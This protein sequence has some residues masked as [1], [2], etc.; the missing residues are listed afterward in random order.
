MREYP[1]WTSDSARM[2]YAEEALAKL[3][4][5]CGRYKEALAKGDKAAQTREIAQIDWYFECL[6]SWAK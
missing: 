5:A 3:R 4:D 2:A 1:H 6:R